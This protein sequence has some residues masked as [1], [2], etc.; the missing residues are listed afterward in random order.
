MHIYLSILIAYTGPKDQREIICD[1]HHDQQDYLI[2]Y[3]V[4]A[5]ESVIASCTIPSFKSKY[6]TDDDELKYQ[7]CYIEGIEEVCEAL[8]D[9]DHWRGDVDF[10]SLVF[11][12]D[13]PTAD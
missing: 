10:I 8:R 11:S 4:S 1:E 2:D 9:E 7:F 5:L 13:I 12:H 6:L 3:A